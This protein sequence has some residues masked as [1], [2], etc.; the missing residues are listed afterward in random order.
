MRK[1]KLKRGDFI[2]LAICAAIICLPLAAAAGTFSGES[3]VVHVAT[4]NGEYLYQLN[5]DR[6]VEIQG[7]IGITVMQIED[8]K[9]RFLESPCNGKD[10]LHGEIVSNGEQ[11]ACLPNGVMATL[12]GADDGGVDGISY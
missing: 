9:V 5:Q 3:A 12:S 11:I 2:I 10:C 8:S 7:L 4:P 6:T 1:V